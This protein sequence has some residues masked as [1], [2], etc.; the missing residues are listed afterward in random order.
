MERTLWAYNPS[1]MEELIKEQVTE[2][3]TKQEELSIEPPMK[4]E[5]RR[6]IRKL[7]NNKAPGIDNIPGELIKYGGE[8]LLSRLDDLFSKI[9]EMEQM[10]WWASV[11]H[12]IYKKRDKSV[13]E[14][15]HGISLLSVSYKIFSSVIKERLE[16]HA[17]R[18]LGEYQAGFKR[19]IG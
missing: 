9:W 6:A 2:S 11:L 5:I 14:N 17:E 18:I 7:K 12:P 1:Q 10:D 3:T 16:L 4:E 13:C 15:Y 19:G 8:V